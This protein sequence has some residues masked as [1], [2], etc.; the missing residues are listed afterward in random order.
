MTLQPRESDTIYDSVRTTLEDSIDKLTHFL[1]GSFNDAIVS[2][3][4]QQV[5]EAEIKALAA[6]LAGT[7]DYAGKELDE[8][9]LDDLGVDNLE[10]DEINEYMD[11][12]HLDLLA[13]NF[14]IE[15]DPGSKA[16]VEVEIETTDDSVEIDEGYIVATEP[17]T[18]TGSLDF[19]VDADDDGVIDPDSDATSSPSTGSTTVTVTAIA[20]AV[21]SEYNV[22]GG[23]ITHMP[24]PEPGILSVTNSTAATG[25]QDEQSNDSLRADVKRSIFEQSE[26]GTVSGIERAVLSDSDAT[27]VNVDEFVDSDPPFCDVVVDGGDTSTLR[28]VIAESKPAGIKHNLVRPEQ[29]SV[30]VYTGVVGDDANASNVE[31]VVTSYLDGLRVGD[32]FY[33]SQLLSNIVSA[34]RAIITVPGLTT[35]FTTVDNERHSYVSGTDVYELNSGPFGKVINEHHVVGNDT[36]TFETT[37]DQ[38]DAS[39]VSVSIV[40]DDVR[41]SLSG[42]EF[43]VIDDSGDGTNDTI[44]LDDSLDPDT[45]SIVIIDYEHGDTSIDAVDGEDGTTYTLGTDVE[46]VDDDGDGLDESID[47]SVGDNSPSDGDRFDVTYTPNRSFSG[48]RSGVDSRLFAPDAD[49]LR[50]DVNNE[51]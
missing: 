30:G 46:L 39:S 34:D 19:M 1:P 28:D 8:S 21:G 20:S 50:V 38:V 15:R 22:G 5:R 49:T 41:S 12:Q 48:D 29:I 44:D 10:P 13:A 9:D 42:S 35:Y 23:T 4:S 32:P 18:G 17:S 37:F 31:T 14:T 51:T 47:F 26:G 40:E 2:A 24:N 7:I 27:S 45:G 16:T 3:H 43:S 11:D 36:D 6:E 33:E 25:G